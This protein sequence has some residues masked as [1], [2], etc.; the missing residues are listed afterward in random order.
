[1]IMFETQ[2]ALQLV[3]KKTGGRIPFAYLRK[4]VVEW[5]DTSS[6]CRHQQMAAIFPACPE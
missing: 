2:Q 4:C 3:L 1:M 5:R 6:G